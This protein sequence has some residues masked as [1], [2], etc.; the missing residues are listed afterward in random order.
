MTGAH[1]KSP[2]W[3]APARATPARC[4]TEVRR[5]L[6]GPWPTGAWSP[7]PAPTKPGYRCARPDGGRSRHCR[8]GKGGIHPGGHGPKAFRESA[9]R[10]HEKRVAIGRLCRLVAARHTAS[11]RLRPSTRPRRPCRR[12]TA[13]RSGDSKPSASP[14]ERDTAAA[15]AALPNGCRYCRSPGP[16]LRGRFVWLKRKTRLMTS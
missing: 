14:R 8:L 16:Y 2:V 7:T 12:S 1:S 15:R 13:Q 9:G 11:C 6:L 4:S 5:A 3:P 10:P